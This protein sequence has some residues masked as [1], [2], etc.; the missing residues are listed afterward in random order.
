MPDVV[1]ADHRIAF[2]Q[3]EINEVARKLLT[4]GKDLSVWA[5]HG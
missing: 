5:L 2:T 3:E 4:A 1:S